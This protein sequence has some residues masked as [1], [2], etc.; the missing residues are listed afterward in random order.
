[1]NFRDLGGLPADGGTVRSGVLFRSDSLAYAT[2]T[3]ATRLVDEFG[4]ATVIDLRGEYEVEQLGRGPLAETKVRYV[5]APIVDVTR[6]DELARHYLAILD[7]RGTVLAD[8]VRLITEPTALPAV[9][10]CEAG[11]DR[12]GVFAAV[13]LGLLGVTEDEIA[14]DYELTAPAM[15]EIH[16]RIQR[17][18]AQLGLPPRNVIDWAPQAQMMADTLALVR[19]RWGGIEEWAATHG[20]SEED[21]ANLRTALLVRI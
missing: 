3:D 5:H 12:T 15:P 21:I 14:T 11:C 1:M 20:L 13:V 18:I 10:H 4:L 6:S 17:T 8:L 16:A 7:E 9:F 2:K 19:E